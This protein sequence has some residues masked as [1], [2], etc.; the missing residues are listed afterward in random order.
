[1]S[2]KIDELYIFDGFSK[3]EIT[4][5]LLMS[6]TQYRKK[7]ERI[8]SIGDIS[9]GCAYYIN[10]G[11][12]RVIQWGLEVAILGPGSFFGEI[13][14]ITDEPRTATVEVIDDVELQVFLKDD[15]LTLLKQSPH[16]MQMRTEIMRRIKDRIKHDV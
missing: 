2:T 9:N 14:L 16:G 7:W 15:F 1:M 13:A 5:F 8:L 10:S 11:N 3:E 12:V 6:Q 4:Y